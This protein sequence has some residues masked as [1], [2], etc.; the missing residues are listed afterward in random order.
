MMR[1]G[2]WL[3]ELSFHHV[4][5]PETFVFG[6]CAPAGCAVQVAKPFLRRLFASA[7]GSD[8]CRLELSEWTRAADLQRAPILLASGPRGW[9]AVGAV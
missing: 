3:A 1:R 6:L 5:P 9:S 2:F 4:A 8:W 7:E